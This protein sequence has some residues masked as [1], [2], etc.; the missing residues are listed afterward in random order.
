MRKILFILTLLLSGL[1][2]LGQTKHGYIDYDKVV[3]T[4][5]EY[6]AELKHLET[7][8]R[9]LQ[10]SL[11][12]MMTEYQDYLQNGIPHNVELDSTD[13]VSLEN[14]IRN[15][16]KKIQDFQQNAQVEINKDQK[17]VETKLKDLI[18]K[19]LEQY[20]LD[21]DIDCVVDKKAILHCSNCTDYTDDFVNYLNKRK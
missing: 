10:D 2:T 19:E 13:K 7:K 15:M 11:N 20:C 3:Q 4:L 9:Q 16:G 6:A 5:P 12:A 8:N 14:R 21:K 1:T 18:T 17:L